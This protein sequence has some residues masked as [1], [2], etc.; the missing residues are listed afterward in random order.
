MF[1]DFAN[2]DDLLHCVAVDKNAIG[3]QAFTANRYPVRFVLFDNFRDSYKFVEKM[4]TEHG[5]L[6]ESVENWFDEPHVDVMFTHSKVANKFKQFVNEHQ[7]KDYV[8]TPFSEL[9]RFYDNDKVPEFH[10]LISTIKGIEN[11]CN[12]SHRIYV[13]VVGLEGKFSQFENDSQIHVWYFRNSDQQLNYRLIVT[14][15]STYGVDGL[16]DKFTMVKDMREW[17]QLW[18]NKNAKQDIISISP[19][20][21]AHIKYAQPDNAFSYCECRNVYDFVTKGLNL[22]FGTLDYKTVGTESNI[23]KVRERYA[24]QMDAYR[25]IVAQTYKIPISAVETTLLILKGDF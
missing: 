20:I 18:R 22:N 15:G 6:V 19:T 4:Q 8:V 24:G 2:I 21:F 1:K 17:L 14:N 23:S 13:P 5:C 10:T 12:P 16:E 3:S 9:V 11:D 25:Q 7:E